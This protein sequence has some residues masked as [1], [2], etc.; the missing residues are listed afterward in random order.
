M[1]GMSDKKR[2]RLR[3]EILESIER[4]KRIHQIALS[5]LEN[6]ALMKQFVESYLAEAAGEEGVP[7]EEV[8]ARLGLV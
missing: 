7:W 4:E 6:K 8:K 1:P 5:T 2:E 3:R